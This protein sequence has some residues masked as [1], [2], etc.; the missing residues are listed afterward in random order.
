MS[1]PKVTKLILNNNPL[2]DF[3]SSLAWM[4]NIKFL[5]FTDNILVNIHESTFKS[6]SELEH[7]ILSNSQIYGIDHCSFCSQHSLKILDLSNS[8]MFSL[9]SEMLIGL[10]SIEI[11]SFKSTIV[12]YVSESI[13]Q[14]TTLKVLETNDAHFCCLRNHEK[15]LLCINIDYSTLR[16]TCSMS[17]PSFSFPLFIY[18]LLPFALNTISVIYIFSEKY[19]QYLH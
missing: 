2:K 14:M 7:L 6:L 4:K 1:F 19:L 11:L 3:H 8:R 15:V 10:N 5:E 9:T 18:L 12:K 16:Q 17:N 13:L